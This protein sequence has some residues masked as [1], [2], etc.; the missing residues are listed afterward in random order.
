MSCADTVA[1]PAELAIGATFAG[2]N[3]G[4]PTPTSSDGTWTATAGI[5]AGTSS[6]VAD[7]IAESVAASARAAAILAFFAAR[8]A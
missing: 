5:C 8:L 6:P 2:D 7:S 4:A 3:I 1:D